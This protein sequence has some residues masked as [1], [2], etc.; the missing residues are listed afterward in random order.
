M[1]NFSNSSFDVID[2]ASIS[3]QDQKYN[4]EEISKGKKYF[5]MFRGYFFALLFAFFTSISDILIK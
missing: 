2:T 3:S 1:A 5:L 4:E